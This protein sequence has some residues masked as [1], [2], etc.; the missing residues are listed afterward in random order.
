M[1]RSGTLQ[2]I[3]GTAFNAARDVVSSKTALES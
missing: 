2:F 1:N 3:A